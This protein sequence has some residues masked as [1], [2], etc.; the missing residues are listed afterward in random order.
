MRERER[1]ESKER[2]RQRARERVGKWGEAVK[3][4]GGEIGR[5]DDH[6]EL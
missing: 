3:A 6:D 1:G 2:E 5:E 4:R